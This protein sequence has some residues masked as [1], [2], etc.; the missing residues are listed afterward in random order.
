MT[1]EQQ[2]ASDAARMLSALGKAA[3]KKKYG[4]AIFKKMAQASRDRIIATLTPEQRKQRAQ[5]I[6]REIPFSHLKPEEYG[7]AINAH[8]RAKAERVRGLQASEE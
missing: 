6:R 2:A 5:L 1:N 4:N 3:L 8:D 7:A